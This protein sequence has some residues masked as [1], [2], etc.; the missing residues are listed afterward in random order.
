MIFYRKPFVWCPGRMAFA[1]MIL[2]LALAQ[3]ARA[4]EAAQF[5]GDYTGGAEVVSADGTRVHRDMSVSIS[6]TKDGFTVQW[7]SVTH[8]PDGRTKEKSHS[9][10]FRPSDRDGIFSAAMGRS[11][12]G[13]AVQLDPMKGEPYV[14]G[15]I[16]GDT[17]SVFSLFIDDAGGY[18]MQQ[19]D[20]TLAEGGLQLDFSFSRNGEQLRSFSTFL[21]RQ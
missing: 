13:Q 9:I 3:P 2:L 19:Y 6:E 14:W 21:A 16:S 17:L 20:R 5:I 8:K 12:F 1:A 18:E 7:T 4:G 10:D 15:R 11:V